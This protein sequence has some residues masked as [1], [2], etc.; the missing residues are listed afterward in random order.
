MFFPMLQIKRT[1][2][3]LALL[4]TKSFK[5]EPRTNLVQGILDLRRGDDNEK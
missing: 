5:K 1:F 4:K 3:H 2:I